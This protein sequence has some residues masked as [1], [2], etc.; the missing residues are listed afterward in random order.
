MNM[1]DI[2]YVTGLKQ[3]V[4]AVFD[5]PQGK[6]V[7]DF[8]ELSSG[9]YQSVFDPVNRDMSLINDGKRQVVATI[10]TLLKFSPEQIVALAKSKEQE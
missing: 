6:E 2:G 8:L 3:N 10:K 4:H 5:T 7:M 9:W 1:A